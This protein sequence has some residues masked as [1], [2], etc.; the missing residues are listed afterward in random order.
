LVNPPLLTCIISRIGS[1][2]GIG[3]A[4]K[5]RAAPD[6]VWAYCVLVLLQQFE[7]ELPELMAAPK[8][9]GADFGEIRWS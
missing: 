1:K 9:L 6:P 8:E 5:D 4:F 3:H 7:D 2:F